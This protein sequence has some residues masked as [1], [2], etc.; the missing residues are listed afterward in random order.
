M[1]AGQPIKHHFLP[2]FY[3]KRW[4]QTD[5]RL[6]EFSKPFGNEVKPKRVHPEGTGYISRL[7]AIQ[8]LPDE[9]AHEMEREF[10]S[11]IDSR[12]A[13]ALNTM[14]DGGE[15]STTQRLA[16]AGFLAT[17]LSRMPSDI[18]TLHESITELFSTIVPGFESIFQAL[19]PENE[20]RTFEQMTEELLAKAAPRVI[21]HAKR[22]MSNQRLISGL[23]AME[24]SVLTVDR[25]AHELLTSDRPVIYT[26]VLGQTDSHVI[27]PI[28]PR[29]M[30][31]G[32]NDRTL[33]ERIKSMGEDKLVS[34]TN[35][36]VVGAADKFVYGRSDSQSRF[37]QNRMGE[38]QVPSLIERMRVLQR[39]RSD[40]V[41][42][43]LREL[44][45]PAQHESG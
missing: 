41:L 20:V 30:F 2:V 4:A 31:I 19:K 43:L 33:I 28:G 11:P 34:G 13:D 9:V 12:A 10:L 16:W 42:K 24:W 22:L 37:V 38:A 7:Y 39:S 18:K 27:V 1:R 32:V 45:I 5:G 6:V 36:A 26:N 15:F 14:L 25:A 40:E 29:R 44:P 17:L 8:G 35:A 3:L 21:T 23:A